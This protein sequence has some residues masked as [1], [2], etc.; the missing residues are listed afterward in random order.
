MSS[1]EVKKTVKHWFNGQAADFIFFIIKRALLGASIAQ[2][3]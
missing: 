2:S 3:V 1:D